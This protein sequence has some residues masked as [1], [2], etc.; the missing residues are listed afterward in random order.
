MELAKKGLK[1]TEIAAQLRGRTR[2][3]VIGL[4]HRR[5]I[6]MSIF[7]S[8]PYP[9]RT[10]RKQQPSKPKI[11]AKPTDPAVPKI[12]DYDLDKLFIESRLD[13]SYGKVD[14]IDAHRSQC[15]WI[16]GDD[17]MVCGEPIVKS[18]SWCKEHY[19]RA[20]TPYSVARAAAAEIKKKREVEKWPDR[21][22]F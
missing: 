3:A 10:P 21:K 1:A 4:L 12:R 5:K 18:S 13:V 9:T 2:N 11:T 6:M 7:Q 16:E 8:K 15:K 17:R 14:L 19:S 22:K 20:F